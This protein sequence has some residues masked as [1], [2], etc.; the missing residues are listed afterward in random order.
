M[1]KILIVDDSKQTRKSLREIF[2]K[3]GHAVVGEAG[4][5][6]EA[7]KLF[8]DLSPDVVM[9]DIIM[10][11]LSGIETLRLLRS[12]D[13]DVNVIMTSALDTLDRVRECK[14]AGAS[15]YILKPFE[16]TKVMEIIKKVLE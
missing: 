8:R 9:L 1:A 13:K 10:P 2:E 4:T 12:L 14:N 5:G 15:H 16:E 11:Q 6:I 3:H 7:I